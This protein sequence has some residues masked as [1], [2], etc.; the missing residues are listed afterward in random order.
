ML[1]L[2]RTLEQ[3]LRHDGVAKYQPAICHVFWSQSYRLDNYTSQIQEVAISK[4]ELY[5][6]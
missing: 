4:N 5:A 6:V 3:K 2:V 1:Y